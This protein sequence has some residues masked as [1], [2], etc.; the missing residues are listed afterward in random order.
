MYKIKRF[1]HAQES[2]TNKVEDPKQQR[3]FTEGAGHLITVKIK[4]EEKA[5]ENDSN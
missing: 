4:R 5:S 1:N 2:E 3:D